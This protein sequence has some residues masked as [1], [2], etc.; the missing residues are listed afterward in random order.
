MFSALV[1]RNCKLFF[2]DRGAF[3]TALIT[4]LIL[5]VLYSTFLANV[6]RDSLRSAIPEGITVAEKLIDGTVGGQFIASLLAISC[7]TITFCVNLIMI[8][9]RA[10]GT[11]RDLTIT[12]VIYG[13]SDSSK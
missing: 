6:Y 10:N 8:V 7:V 1:K 3:L 13:F 4:P 12:P 11:V 9:D 2:K 5:L